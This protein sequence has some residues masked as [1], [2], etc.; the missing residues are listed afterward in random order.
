MLQSSFD[1]TAYTLT[2]F[3]KLFSFLSVTHFVILKY[4]ILYLLSNAE[5]YSA[6]DS[7]GRYNSLICDKYALKISILLAASKRFVLSCVA[8]ECGSGISNK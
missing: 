5:S 1:K 4:R 7:T 2:S 3:S 8:A 6:D